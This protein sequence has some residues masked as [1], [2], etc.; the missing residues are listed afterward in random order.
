ML[1]APVGQVLQA[2][3]EDGGKVEDTHWSD[4]EGLGDD[5]TRLTALRAYS[6]RGTT[7]CSSE[8]IAVELTIRVLKARPDLCVGFDL[9]ADDGTVVL[10]QYDT[11]VPEEAA[12]VRKPG[13]YR[14]MCRIPPGLLHGRRYLIAP[15]LG[16]HNQK[17]RVNCDPLISINVVVDHGRT[18]YWVSL[19]AQSRPGVVAPV[20][21]WYSEASAHQSA[22]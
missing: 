18:P 5:G 17:W 14:L 21:K 7:L 22:G 8:T 1:D 20:L 12:R 15:R 13:S 11:D 10:R 9:I 3:L 4:P 6:E 2:Y 19:S 16:I